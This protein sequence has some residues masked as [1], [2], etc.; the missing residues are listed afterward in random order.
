[1]ADAI[2]VMVYQVVIAA[3]FVE[4]KPMRA[5][6]GVPEARKSVEVPVTAVAETATVPVE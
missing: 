3:G 6:T 5:P 4:P 1:V 2:A